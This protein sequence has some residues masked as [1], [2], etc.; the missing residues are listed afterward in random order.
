MK[1]I[2][3][4]IAAFISINA[5]GQSVKDAK[6]LVYKYEYNV[7]EH[8]AKACEE[9]TTKRK[10]VSV[11]SFAGSTKDFYQDYSGKKTEYAD[12]TGNKLTASLI[13]TV[14]SITNAKLK[15]KYNAELL[16]LKELDGKIKYV[17][18]EPYYVFPNTTLKQA[19]K[20]ANGYD[21]Y[22]KCF[23]SVERQG[24]GVGTDLVEVG[25]SKAIVMVWMEIYDKDGNKI[26]DVKGEAKGDES[27]IE[28]VN[29]NTDIKFSDS[30][31]EH[32]RKHVC[33][34]YGKAMDDLIGKM[35]E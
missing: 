19:M 3:L 18:P 27:I 29:A 10:A 6:I 30:K 9:K 24:V 17:Y 15:E 1:I 28:N 22:G 13:D 25:S 26:K 32:I 8:I 4:F 21:W 14:Y 7:N 31:L 34:L 33:M 23:I 5:I 12:A 11:S 20:Y 16:P 35:G 2:S